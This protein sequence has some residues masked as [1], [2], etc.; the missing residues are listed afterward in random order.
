MENRPQV[1]L[2]AVTA[3][4]GSDRLKE[5]AREIMDQGCYCVYR[6]N[7]IQGGDLLPKKLEQEIK[8]SDCVIHLVGPRFGFGPM[9]VEPVELE[10]TPAG[11]YWQEACQ[12]WWPLRDF[13]ARRSYTQ[14]EFD[15]A[16]QHDKPVYVL[17]LEDPE[18]KRRA[19]KQPAEESALQAEHRR[20]IEVRGHEYE[21]VE[22]VATLKEITSKLP[23]VTNYL[24]A[25]IAKLQK[26]A[27]EMQA[28]TSDGTK[29]L[30][31]SWGA[32]L[33]KLGKFHSLGIFTCAV[34]L[35][36]WISYQ[37]DRENRLGPLF[38]LIGLGVI[39]VLELFLWRMATGSARELKWSWRGWFCY[40]GWPLYIC[41]HFLHMLSSWKIVGLATP[42]YAQHT[43]IVMEW[44]DFMGWSKLNWKM[45]LDGQPHYRWQ[46]DN[47]YQAYPLAQ[48]WVYVLLTCCAW[49]LW[50]TFF[51]RVRFP[52][53]EG[54]SQPL[55]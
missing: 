35:V 32:R 34:T 30:L 36:C 4:C 52:K 16:L 51:Y 39:P 12:C 9:D 15:F 41:G 42:E 53:K 18:L 26:Q 1:F 45:L 6:E 28:N 17:L 10:R 31:A 48:P 14:M 21:K 46:S 13:P 7:L 19:E 23:L 3:D 47:G 49:A 2:S 54:N 37:V 8:A 5:L 22:S 33:A 27:T 55:A 50:L 43:R 38:V 40:V 25:C 11:Q 29:A 44:P 24:K 20:A